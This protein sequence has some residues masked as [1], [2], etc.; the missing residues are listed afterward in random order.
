MQQSN[1]IFAA[2][3]IGFILF[4][5]NKGELAT[6]LQFLRGGGAQ[7]PLAAPASGGGGGADNS[8]LNLGTLGNAL[9]GKVNT[10]GDPLSFYNDNPSGTPLLGY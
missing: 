3:L 7:T 6:Y 9:Q 10:T 4:I 8:G 1:V 2:I 5:T